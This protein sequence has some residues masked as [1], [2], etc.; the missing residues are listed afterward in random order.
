MPCVGRDLD[1]RTSLMSVSA[2]NVS[3]QNTGEGKITSEKP[4]L[5]I[6]V[7]VDVRRLE[8]M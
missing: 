2:R 6:V 4:R 1:S 3:P 5:A 7:P 8:I